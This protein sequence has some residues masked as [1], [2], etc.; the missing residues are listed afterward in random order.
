MGQQQLPSLS[1][2]SSFFASA[3]ATTT[4]T[5]G[6]AAAINPFRREDEAELLKQRTHNHRRWSHV[7]PPGEVEFKHA[8]GPNWKSLC[9][10][11]I[12]PLTTDACPTPEQIRKARRATMHVCVACVRGELRGW[13]RRWGCGGGG[14]GQHACLPDDDDDDDDSHPPSL[15]QD[16]T[17]SFYTLMLPEEAESARAP[18]SEGACKA[19]SSSASSSSASQ[20]QQTHAELLEEMVCQRLAQDFQLVETPGHRQDPARANAGLLK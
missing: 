3:S 8:P 10:P 13:G 19:P 11:A 6:V 7:F 12:L 18:D 9:Q 14:E 5:P 20:Q 16:Y 4:T 2:S 17:E 15:Q 1:S